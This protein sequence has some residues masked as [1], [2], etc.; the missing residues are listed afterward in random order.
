METLL[1]EKDD[2]RLVESLARLFEFK[3]CRQSS[4]HEM[5]HE[6]Q[7][8]LLGDLMEALT[9]SE[10]SALSRTEI[11]EISS[12]CRWFLEHHIDIS[13]ILRRLV[14]AP[15]HERILGAIFEDLKFYWIQSVGVRISLCKSSLRLFQI[16]FTAFLKSLVIENGILDDSELLSARFKSS[17]IIVSLSNDSSV[18]P[19]LFATFLGLI[20]RSTE[21]RH[22]NKSIIKIIGELF[23]FL[24]QPLSFF[25]VNIR[26]LATLF[27][28]VDASVRS[29]TPLD[30]ENAKNNFIQ[31]DIA[32]Q[33]L[34]VA[35]YPSAYR[36]LCIRTSQWKQNL[37][38][39]FPA[40]R[41]A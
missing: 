6:V 37:E 41:H 15:G 33:M 11:D 34:L 35:C 4:V 20:K 40:L 27:G 3:F 19:F 5:L 12:C 36:L 13:Q 21:R 2:R 8:Y 28:R 7:E 23:R 26:N 39:L 1:E 18:L 30:L 9:E 25:P 14:S 31:L 16:E 17:P 24:D 38:F 29:L 10:I 22:L 32:T